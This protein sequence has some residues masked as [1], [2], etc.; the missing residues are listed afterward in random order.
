LI[1]P[2]RNTQHTTTHGMQAKKWESWLARLHRIKQ[3]RLGMGICVTN[4]HIS[5]TQ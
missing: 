5:Y 3:A 4:A 1:Y 2:T